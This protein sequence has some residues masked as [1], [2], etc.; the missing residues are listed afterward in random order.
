MNQGCFQT[1]EDFVNLEFRQN[2][3]NTR[4]VNI[5]LNTI[6]S[7]SDYATWVWLLSQI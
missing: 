3:S 5:S 4:P 6:G 2:T 7:N 1:I